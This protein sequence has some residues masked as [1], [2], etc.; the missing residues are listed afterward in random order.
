LI[1]DYYN[2][3]TSDLLTNLPLPSY[4]GFSSVKTNL[5]SY[6]N[7]GYEFTA[8]ANVLNQPGGLKVDVSAN[9]S[10]VKKQSVAIT[11]QRKRKQPAGWPA[12][13]RPS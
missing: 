3:E 12:G 4:T 11:F 1:F 9:A 2:R 7:T 5:G 13:I 6:Q 10:Y 8:T